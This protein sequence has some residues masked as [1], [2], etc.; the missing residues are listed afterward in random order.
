MI[1]VLG[2]GGLIG[3]A[4]ALALMHQGLPVLAMARR[5][6]A[7][8]ATAFGDSALVTGFDTASLTRAFDDHGVDIVVNCVGLLQDDGRETVDD[9]HR[10]IVSRLIEA[11]GNCLLIHISIPGSDADDATPF[12]RS[13]RQADRIIAASSVAHVILRPGFVIAPAAYGGSA[14]IRALAAL[15]LRLPEAEENRPFAITAVSDITRTIAFLAAE[16]RHGNREWHETLDVMA[17]QP[18][19]V[20]EVIGAFR[21]HFG[22]PVPRVRLPSRSLT[23]GSRA[24]DAVA[25]MG[26]RPPVRSTALREMRRG[27]S[28][29]P[30]A[31]IAATGFEP[32]SLSTALS[33]IP[34]TIQ[35]RWFAR[36]YLTKALVLTVLSLFWVV[37]G[38]VALTVAFSAATDILT[39]HG[40]PARI[41]PMITTATSLADIGIGVAIA[42]RR[43]CRYGLLA[44]IMVS[45]VYL[46]AAI[47][48]APALW[49]D[50]VGSLVKTVPTIVL[51]LIGLALLDDR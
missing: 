33:E 50:P 15:P 22:G 29:N 30:S 10:D 28:G 7:S 19:T 13:K 23:L 41:A 3:N 47:A 26:W 34:A 40:F 25:R 43:T 51:M 49:L 5:F 17:R 14:L 32:A 38:C 18:T 37:S 11:A 8:Q 39:G 46:L 6:T 12:S 24:A 44:G 48:F 1:A 16:W 31:W 36:L 9:A 27:V 21:H 2:A 42:V 35:E 4:V 20:G 45:I